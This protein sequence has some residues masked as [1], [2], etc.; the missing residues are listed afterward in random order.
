MIDL[1]T[2]ILPGVDDGP[3]TLEDAAAMVRMAAAAKRPLNWN[4]M[5]PTADSRE[6]DDH[7]LTA[8]RSAKEAGGNVVALVNPFPS[9]LR[10]S[11][12]SGF[13]L[14]TLTYLRRG[15]RIGT[16]TA[17]IGSALSVKPILTIESEI[18]AVERVRT[19]ERGIESLVEFARRQAAA[20]SDAWCPSPWASPGDHSGTG[21]SS[22]ATIST[23]SAGAVSSP[24][25]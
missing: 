7:N 2:H 15:G 20:G 22:S 17:W 24:R 3:A 4:L 1:H 21:A 9:M 18:R 5:N 25:R 13:L 6:I 19:R 14:D 23:S 10:V 16:A 12:Y 11:F 8:Y